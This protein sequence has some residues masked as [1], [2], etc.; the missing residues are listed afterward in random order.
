MTRNLQADCASDARPT[1]ALAILYQ[2]GKFLMQLR[3]DN[4]AIL[5]PGHWGFFGGHLEAGEDAETGVRRELQEEIGYCPRRLTLFNQ[6]EDS[7]VIRYI[8]H[9]V[10][11]RDLHHLILGE[12]MDLG[13]LAPEDIERG[14]RYS[15]KID[16]VRPLGKPHREIL[17][18]FIEQYGS[19][20]KF[21][22][23]E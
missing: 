22:S 12:G 17:L 7:Y 13:L 14:D 4:P 11:D 5:Y 18:D 9:G 6:H 21:L 23:L 16:Q 3:D 8:Y 2:N 15:T 10:L 19:G 20:G 1:V